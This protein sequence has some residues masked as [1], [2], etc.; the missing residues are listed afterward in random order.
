MKESQFS[1]IADYLARQREDRSLSQEGLAEALAEYSRVFDGLDGLAISRWERGI[2]SPSIERQ[3]ALMQFFGDEPH[4]LLQNPT[5]ELKQLPSLGAF[6]KWVQQNLLYNHVM[7]GHPYASDSAG[8]FDKSVPGQAPDRRWLRL[9]SRYTENLTRGRENWDEQALSA[10]ACAP[11]SH[12]VFYSADEQLLGHLIMVRVSDDTLADLLSGHLSD[13]DL[14]PEQL[15]AENTEANLY[16]YTAY[17][18]SRG[19]CED[20]LT[21][22]FRTLLENPANRSLG[23]KARAN[24]GVKLMDVLMGEVVG[25]GAEISGHRDGARY[26]GRYLEHVSYRLMRD[27]LLANPTLLNLVRQS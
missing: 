15:V 27:N 25:K 21:Q 19:I 6:H 11:S 26:Q 4:L 13:A 7:G 2:V 16:P 20:A 1:G 14:G 8:Q 10:L 18:G 24:F 5:Y 12:S 23:F 9:V 17:F 22:V 3:I